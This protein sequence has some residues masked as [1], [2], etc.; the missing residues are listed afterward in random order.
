MTATARFRETECVHNFGLGRLVDAVASDKVIEVDDFV[1]IDALAGFDTCDL[2]LVEAV[3]VGQ[4]HTAREALDGDYHFL[5][6]LCFLCFLCN[7][8]I[9]K[10]Y[11]SSF[12][13]S[14]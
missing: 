1:G 14:I 3:L 10:M 13:E 6:Y 2:F 5:C 12:S 4:H 9:L 7:Y 8:I 11:L